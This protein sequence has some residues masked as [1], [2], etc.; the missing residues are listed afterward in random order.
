[1]LVEQAALE[2]A[3]QECLD[4]AESRRRAR[5]R[6]AVRRSA[7]DQAYADAFA[8]RVAELYPGCPAG[9]AAAIAHHACVVGSGR[10]GR[11]SEAKQLEAHAVELAVRAHVRHAHTDYDELLATGVDRADARAL[12]RGRVDDVLAG[13]SGAD[14]G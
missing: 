12:V 14:A 1:V 3:E 11:S 13:W 7:E 5:E 9:E 10:I 8:R 4:D 6:T 2:R